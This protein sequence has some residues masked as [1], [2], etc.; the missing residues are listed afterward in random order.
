MNVGTSGGAASLQG[1]TIRGL[2]V[3]QR[4]AG[5]PYRYQCVCTHKG[6][7]TQQVILHSVLLTWP[8][9]ANERNHKRQLTA[10]DQFRIDRANEIRQAEQRAREQQEQADRKLHEQQAQ[11]AR[12]QQK[13]DAEQR[14]KDEAAAAKAAADLKERK[15][16]FEI[17]DEV[18]RDMFDHFGLTQDERLDILSNLL[19]S[20]HDDFFQSRVQFL[21]EQA[22]ERRGQR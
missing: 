5:I 18:R 1:Q 15:I 16:K 9:C 21:C 19:P 4:L 12:R 11:A 2:R 22:I 10:D 8:R 7:S 20:D 17:S 14:A 13:L 6:C 3:V